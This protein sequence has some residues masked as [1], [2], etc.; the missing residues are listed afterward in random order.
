[1]A[2]WRRGL[3]AR[4]GALLLPL[5]GLAACAAAA[6]PARLVLGQSLPLSG[7]AF[8]M[9]NRV[10]AGAKVL[11]DRI[12][13]TGGVHG[14]QIEL[15]TLDDQGDPRR[16]ADNVRTLVRQH[17]ALVLL[18]CLG[19]RA[20]SAAAEA[21][22]G[23]GVPLVGAMS[24]E[25]ALRERHNRHV[26]TLRPDDR[27]EALALLGQLK[28]IGVGRV[29]LLGD[30]D[31]PVREQ[32]LVATL[33]SGGIDVQRLR[34]PAP[35]ALAA[36][37]HDAAAASAHALV[38]SLGPASLDALSRLGP[39]A[40]EGL[41]PLLATLA[42][43][44]LTQ[45]TRL[46]RQRALGFSSVVPNPEASQLPLV[47]EFERDV[48]TYGGP[49]AISFEGLAGYMAA[50]LSVEALRR[51]GAQAE[52]SSVARAIEGLGSFSLGGF[53][54]N[55]SAERHHGSDFVEIGVR[56]RDGRTRR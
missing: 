42:D 51:A 10:L 54:L 35:A 22:R 52:P 53:P 37:L 36:S 32:V 14:R 1:V 29:V 16:M 44:G 23:L 27:R 6:Q 30:G 20:C 11:V 26:F 45:L 46:V 39:A 47:R 55:F 13:A 5:L 48:D 49:E 43:P 2:G 56:S 18:N 50:R 24:G 4:L 12:N 34:L 17:R 3:S 38:L 21:S 41:P 8:P 31:A 28:A 33:Q 25:A 15:V 19:E 40:D 9:A 7:P